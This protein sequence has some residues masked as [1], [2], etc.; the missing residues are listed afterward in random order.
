MLR[1]FII[2]FVSATAFIAAARFIPGIAVEGWTAAFIAAFLLGVFNALI[3]P[4]VMLVALPIN[5]LTLGLF[6]FVVNVLAFWALGFVVQGVAVSGFIPA[7]LGS[8]AISLVVSLAHRLI[9][10]R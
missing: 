4:V 7:V 3:R 1:L 6:G 5:L 8:V 10:S 9:P 2:W